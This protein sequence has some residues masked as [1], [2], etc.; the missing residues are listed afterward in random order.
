MAS[1]RLKSFDENSV[2]RTN[3]ALDT[4]RTK[5]R[6]KVTIVIARKRTPAHAIRLTRYASI[7]L[8]YGAWPRAVAQLLGEVLPARELEGP[9][10]VEQL[11]AGALLA[12]ADL[13][14][15]RWLKRRREELVVL[16]EAEIAELGAF[17]QRN[18]VEVDHDP[19]AGALGNVRGVDRD[20][21]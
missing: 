15:A 2:R 19:A 12:A 10:V 13:G 5:K 7:A 4:G 9:A 6:M 18:K 16:A 14:E 20:P 8:H 11:D 1:E 17:G 21:V 3:C